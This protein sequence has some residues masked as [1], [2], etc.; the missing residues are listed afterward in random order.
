MALMARTT[1]RRIYMAKASPVV[2]TQQAEGWFYKRNL[3]P[4]T[5]QTVA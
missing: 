3:S 4:L 5:M 2:L 1:V